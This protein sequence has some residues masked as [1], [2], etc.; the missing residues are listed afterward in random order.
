MKYYQDSL[1]DQSGGNIMHKHTERRITLLFMLGVA[2]YV[3]A[4]CLFNFHGAQWYTFDMYEDAQFARLAAEGRTLFPS[5][6]LF[7]NQCYVIATPVIAA[8]LYPLF[9]NS[10]LAM[11]AASTVMMFLILICFVWCFHPFFRRETIAIGLF[12]MAGG[13]LLGDSACSC[14]EGMQIVYTMASFY[15]CYLL[16]FLL[17]L[18]VWLRFLE[19]KT[20]ALPVVLAI[21][22]GFCLG[23]QSAREML[24]LNLP[25]L[26]L[27]A[28]LMIYRPDSGRFAFR[29][30]VGSLIANGTGMLISRFLPI[31]RSGNLQAAAGSEEA[32]TVW[33]RIRESLSALAKM[34]GLRYWQYSWKWKPLALLA[35]GLIA[36][37][38]FCLVKD[39]KKKEPKQPGFLAVLL[40]WISLMGVL[41]AGVT[42]IRLRPIYFFLWFLLVPVSVMELFELLPPAA[43]RK[44]LCVFLLGCGLLNAVFSFYPD[45]Q[46]Y[47]EQR[48]WFQQIESWLE[49]QDTEFVYG[50]YQVPAIT[51]VSGDRIK[52][53]P[54]FPREDA[55]PEEPLLQPFSSPVSL[56]LYDRVDPGH[57][58]MILSDSVYDEFS[59]YRFLQQG[60]SES[61]RERFETQFRLQKVFSSPTLTYYIYSFEEEELFVR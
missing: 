50:D 45:L 48:A 10:V 16:V 26:L 44:M 20:S 58:V 51:A 49:E 28:V 35:C 18:G 17:H 25:L 11:G 60:T 33:H 47:R 54:L 15:A 1:A 3:A 30:S 13:T 39:I 31:Q 12:C 34:T 23:I 4:I 55:M 52:Y 8:L 57:S 5:G 29:F 53:C 19:K 38:V 27:S 14:V 36:I 46:R 43:P 24:L 6:W 9:H 61:Y 21:L 40:C 56:S 7:G 42:V 32:V 2:L 37:C 41:A 22:S 59:G